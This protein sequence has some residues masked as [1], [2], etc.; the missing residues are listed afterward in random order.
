MSKIKSMIISILSV[1]LAF[2]GGLIAGFVCAMAVLA[3]VGTGSWRRGGRVGS[4][5]YYNERRGA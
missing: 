3:V 5:Y 4:S 2:G 1:A